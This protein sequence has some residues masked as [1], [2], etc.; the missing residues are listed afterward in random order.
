MKKNSLISLII[1]VGLSSVGVLSLAHSGFLLTDDG[2]SMVI[3]FSAFYEALRDGQFPVRFLHRLNYG[4]GYPVADFLYPLFMYIGIPIKAIGF[5]FVDTVKIIFVIGFLS[6][7]FF[8]Y[9]WLRKLFDEKSAF[10]GSV[11]YSLFPYHLFDIYKRGSVGEVLALGIVPFI[12]WAIERNNWSL[13]SLGYALLITAHNSLAIIF[14]PVIF[15]YHSLFKSLRD[16][17]GSLILGLGLSAFFWIPALHDK[18][19]TV[20]DTVRVSNYKEYFINSADII[21][22]GVIFFVSLIFGIFSYKSKNK[23]LIFFLIL[24]VISLLLSLPIS[25][26]VWKVFP[27]SSI[28]QFPF[29]FVSLA[30]LSTSFIL[31]FV[32]Y[33]YKS[34]TR[35]LFIVFL[36]SLIFI[37]ARSFLVPQGTQTLPDAFYSTNQDSTTVKNEYMP[38]WVKKA[39][40]QMYSSKVENLNG[41]E[42]INLESV[43]ANKISFNTFLASSREIRVNTVYFP[44]W[45]AYVNG[46]KSNIIYNDGL[47][48]LSLEKGRN[49]VLI[50]FEE[51]PVRVLANLVSIVSFLILVIFS[52]KKNVKIF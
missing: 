35:S 11:V 45:T 47:I 31:A 8:S 17:V 38:K 42:K 50:K 20:F 49:E 7:T 13:I 48:N 36:I 12:F 28:I 41:E 43:S 1:A 40:T 29:R 44:G 14:I 51:T 33:L 18:Q 15:L 9:L 24:S 3:R 16:S 46:R 22:F 10:I 23:K 52:L 21:L 5:S 30:I 26:L 27:L 32:V 37:S 4:F 39:P 25:D 19:F 34:R 6:G 2:N